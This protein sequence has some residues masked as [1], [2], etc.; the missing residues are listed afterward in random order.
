[1]VR[2][3]VA[4]VL[5]VA[6]GAAGIIAGHSGAAGASTRDAGKVVSLTPREDGSYDLT[7]RS[8]GVAGHLVDETAVLWVPDKP[9]SGNVVAWAHAT[10]GLA[11]QCAPSVAGVGDIPSREALLAAGDVVVAPDYEGLGVAGVHPY[12]VGTSEG[13]SVL[14]AIRAAKS[15][16]GATGRSV[17][18]GWSQGGQAALFAARI[19]HAYAPDARLSGA[20]AIAPVMNMTSMVDGTSTLS[21][22]PGVV[23]MVAAGYVEAYPELK[24]SDL[25]GQSLTQ[26]DTARSDC[27]AAVHLDGTTVHKPSAEW[28]RRLRQNDPATAKIGVPVMLSHGR[29]D[30]IL[31]VSDVAA[32]YRRLCKDGTTVTLD[33]YEDAD[34]QSVVSASTFDVFFWL[35]DRLSGIQ[36]SGCHNAEIPS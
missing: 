10:K 15:V 18:Y 36:T 33:W 26:L 16:T 11:D 17:V 14:D 28:R 7:Y 31:G 32:A 24:P 13:R 8:L 2:R 3:V 4:V 29:G 6:F 25:L 19:A 5:V 35:E 12:L 27:D 23:A 21:K 30:Y 20:A 1:M 22:L 34:H 9:R